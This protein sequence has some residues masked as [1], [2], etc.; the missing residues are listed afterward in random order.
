MSELPA[1]T[2]IEYQSLSTAGGTV[3]DVR[4]VFQ[5]SLEPS[6]PMYSLADQKV[7][8][9]DSVDHRAAVITDPEIDI[10]EPA[11]GGRCQGGELP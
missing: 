8:P 10:E 3:N 9:S 11:A 1:A 5:M 7:V 4:C 2:L 6:L